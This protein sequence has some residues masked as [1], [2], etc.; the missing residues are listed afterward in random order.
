[1]AEITM[2]K[3]YYSPGACS[4]A[5]HIVLEEIGQPYEKEIVWTDP[6]KPG[7]TVSSPEW[8]KINPKGY[9]PVL[10]GVTGNSGGVA[11]V[12]TEANAILLYL[13]RKFP[14]A[15]LWPQT[16]EK[17]ARCME[18]LTFI[19][20]TV[21][22]NSI[23]QIWRPAR[24]VADETIFP[25]VEARGR[26][27][28]AEQFAFIESIFSCGRDWAVPGQ[29]TVADSYILVVYRWGNRLGIDM[30]QYSFWTRHTDRMLARAA[31]VRT[32]EDEG[33]TMN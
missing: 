4:F 30:K 1:V 22:G 32:M 8:K 21:H 31:V 9:V 18:W 25:A 16:A 12:L 20:G 10:G 7:M 15:N 19:S 3:L 17:E 33:I 6:S 23:A 27:R 29:Y 5:P 2:L 26:A 14:E 11:D 28:L 13:G 24:F